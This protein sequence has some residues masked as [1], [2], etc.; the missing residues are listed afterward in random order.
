MDHFS[1]LDIFTL[2]QN[3]PLVGTTDIDRTEMW[4]LFYVDNAFSKVK[5][6]IPVLCH[7]GYRL[8]DV[9]DKNLEM[10]QRL[11][12]EVFVFSVLAP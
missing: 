7:V 2:I 8:L 4:Y 11:D 9:L 3:D 5:I 12:Q 10:I 6:K 1:T